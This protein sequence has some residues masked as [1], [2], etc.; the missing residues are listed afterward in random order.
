MGAKALLLWGNAGCQ[1]A[2][3]LGS[4][5]RTRLSQR[6]IAILNCALNVGIRGDTCTDSRCARLPDASGMGTARSDMALV[7]ATRRDQFP[8]FIQPGDAG[9]TGNDR[10]AGRIG[11]GQ[12]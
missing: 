11:E 8:G 10:S 2:T 9:V 4:P 1:S 12:H 5:W 7:A 6:R 3:G